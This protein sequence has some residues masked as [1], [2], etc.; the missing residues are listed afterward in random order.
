[1]ACLMLKTLL[2]KIEV[3]RAK[4]GHLQELVPR[5][6]WKLWVYG[7]EAER[8]DESVQV[9]RKVLIRLANTLREEGVIDER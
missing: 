7:K 6:Q 9:L 3:I 2:R 5:E 1:M 4:I 8:A